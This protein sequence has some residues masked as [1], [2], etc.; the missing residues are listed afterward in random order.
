MEICKKKLKILVDLE[1]NEE[2]PEAILRQEEEAAELSCELKRRNVGQREAE[3]A[4]IAAEEQLVWSKRE[5]FITRKQLEAQ[6]AMYVIVKEF[7]A[8]N[9]KIEQSVSR[10]QEFNWKAKNIERLNVEYPLDRI[11][12]C[13]QFFK[14]KLMKFS[15]TSDP[16]CSLD[17]SDD[18]NKDKK[19]DTSDAQ[20]HLVTVG[21]SAQP[22]RCPRSTS[23]TT[24]PTQPMSVKW[25]NFFLDC[26]KHSPLGKT[27][28]RLS[29]LNI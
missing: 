10:L 11:N 6:K 21:N 27:N 17:E 15:R 8:S 12:T 1:K 29:R 26:N 2:N 25:Q 13:R 19:I 18:E 14:N 28:R 9:V 3:S 7:E 4:H 5:L 16:K 22:P 24:L 23:K 20:K